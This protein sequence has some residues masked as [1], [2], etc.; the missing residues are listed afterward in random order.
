M[1]IVR[2]G[3]ASVMNRRPKK[4]IGRPWDL[5][6]NTRVSHKVT[7]K[8]RKIAKIIHQNGISVYQKCIHWNGW[9]ETIDV[10]MAKLAST[11]ELASPYTHQR[12]SSTMLYRTGCVDH[13]WSKCT[14]GAGWNNKKSLLKQR[15]FYS[16]YDGTDITN[17]NV[18]KYF[19]TLKLNLLGQI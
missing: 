19:G 6:V 17:I 12:G 7:T 9:T 16:T 15:T 8:R 14:L 18:S 11:L 5:G 13:H 2:A 4:K 10:H 1:A 3:C